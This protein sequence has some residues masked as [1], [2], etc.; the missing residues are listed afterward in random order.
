MD[1]ARNTKKIHFNLHSTKEHIVAMFGPLAAW[2]PTEVNQDRIR[3]S[4]ETRQTV[5]K[6][7]LE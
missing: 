5:T 2:A 4:N 1:R 6:I 7:E 3:T